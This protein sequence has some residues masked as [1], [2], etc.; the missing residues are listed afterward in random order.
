MSKPK[1]TSLSDLQQAQ[2]DRPAVLALI[3]AW[4]EA[5]RI[6]PIVEGARVHLPVLVVDDGSV[7]ETSEVARAVGVAVVRHAQNQGKGAALKTGFAWALEHGYDAVLTL[8]ADGQ[9]DPAEI[10]KFLAAFE[11][12][13]GD[14]II[15]ARD[16]SQM[17]WPRWWSQPLGCWLLSKALG[18]P[19][20]DNQSGYRLL[21]RRLLERM[22]LTS[23]GFEMEVEMIAEAV[24]L[25]LP[26]AWVPIRTIYGIGKPSNFHPLW[27]SARFLQMVW[28]IWRDRRRG[29]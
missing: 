13:A 28:R 15:G 3:P 18:V 12:G 25:G 4:N 17:P 29:W 8:D 5:E 27:D 26:I 9:H 14:L 20:K 16:F 23:T 24:R 10:P 22:R 7:D 11:A 2:A 1:Q 19:I 21:T 6:G